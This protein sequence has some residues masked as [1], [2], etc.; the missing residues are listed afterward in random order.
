MYHVLNN[1]EVTQYWREGW[2]EEEEGKYAFVMVENL[3]NRARPK[4]NMSERSKV[5][6]SVGDYLK[7]FD[8]VEKKTPAEKIKL[9]RTILQKR[10][11]FVRLGDY[12]KALSD[13]RLL[14]AFERAKW[15]GVQKLMDHRR[16]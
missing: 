7:V 8:E 14:D 11:E 12:G 13:Q 3:H 6:D 15:L 5:P 4:I 16:G 9:L 10:P 1:P 2:R